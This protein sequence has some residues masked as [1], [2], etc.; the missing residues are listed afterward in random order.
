MA[1]LNA[2]YH[3]ADM[4]LEKHGLAAQGWRF[5]LD[6]ARRRFGLCRTN[7][8]V[9]QVSKHLARLNTLERVLQTVLH[10][11]AHA[12]TPGHG[13]DRVWQLKCIELGIPARRC[14]DAAEVATPPAPLIAECPKCGRI[15][16]RHRMPKRRIS[17]GH[18][19]RQFSTDHELRFRR[20][21]HYQR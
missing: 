13:H 4:L 5:E 3:A 20:D 17:C 19:T 10:E 8:K 21:V 2:V 16:R 6:N 9:I 12:L 1:N 15:V 14:F 7:R 18:C 11:I